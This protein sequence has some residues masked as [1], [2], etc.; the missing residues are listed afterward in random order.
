MCGFG[1]ADNY[2]ALSS[3]AQFVPHIRVQTLILAAEDDP[4]IPVEIFRRL[5]P[6]KS[7]IVHIASSGGHLGYIGRR[8][9]D[10]DR[11]WMDWRRVVDSIA[12][13]GETCK[14]QRLENP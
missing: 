8:G 10:P 11:R 14:S 3:A 2:Y 6:S 4:L 7:T 13:K 1:T 12:G 5:T 9:I